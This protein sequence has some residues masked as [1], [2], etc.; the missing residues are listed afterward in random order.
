VCSESRLGGMLYAEERS[1]RMMK[2][3]P[4]SV[5]AEISGGGTITRRAITILA[6]RRKALLPCE[7]DNKS[8]HIPCR[9]WKS[10]YCRELV[11]YMME[12]IPALICAF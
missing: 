7:T 2:N 9:W 10:K 5:F 1:V 12:V 8:M 3:G 6:Q 11:V 4:L